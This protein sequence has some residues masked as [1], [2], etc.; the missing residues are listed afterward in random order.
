MDLNGPGEI[1]IKFL[2]L[3]RNLNLEDI[4]WYY[5]ILFSQDYL[6]QWKIC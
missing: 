5:F 3:K 6:N 4:F 2:L 1:C